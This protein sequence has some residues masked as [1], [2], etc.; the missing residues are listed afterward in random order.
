MSYLL[1]LQKVRTI[2]LLPCCLFVLFLCLSMSL[3]GIGMYVELDLTEPKSAVWVEVSLNLLLAHG[4]LI[5][6]LSIL[7]MF[8]YL[9]LRMFER[10]IEP[11]CKWYFP[12]RI[13]NLV[14]VTWLVSCRV[15][16]WTHICPTRPAMLVHECTNSFNNVLSMAHNMA[17]VSLIAGDKMER[18]SDTVHDLMEVTL[19]R[20]S[21]KQG[22]T[23]L[24]NIC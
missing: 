9:N 23:F 24:C 10:D 3:S 18:N 4:M 21:W 15:R 2:V 11:R 6:K 14:T 20:Q 13:S 5:T 7:Y 22:I 16:I 17:D 8:S 12:G 1:K 19:L